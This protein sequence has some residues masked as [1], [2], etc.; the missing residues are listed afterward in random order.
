MWDVDCLVV[1]VVG[2]GVLG[3]LFVSEYAF[4]EAVAEVVGFAN[5]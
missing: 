4:D 5:D 3:S 2:R 1:S